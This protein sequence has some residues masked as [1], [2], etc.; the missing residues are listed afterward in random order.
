MDFLA[1]EPVRRA[2]I[3]DL[4][5][6]GAFLKFQAFGLGFTGSARDLIH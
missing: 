6:N 5:A 1:R 4:V 3:C 2:E